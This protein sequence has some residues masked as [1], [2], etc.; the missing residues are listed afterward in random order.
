MESL[1]EDDLATDEAIDLIQQ[2]LY[3]ISMDETGKDFRDAKE[4]TTSTLDYIAAMK[5]RGNSIL[6]GMD[7]GYAELNRMTAGFGH[8]DLVIIA[9]RPSMG[10]TAFVLNIASKILDHGQGV[11]VFSLEMPAEQLMLRMMSAKASIALQDLRV[12]NLSDE[13]WRV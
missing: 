12:G 8:G 5:E 1:I 2:K 7:T 11:A 3:K 10:K 6:V 13:Q 4:V 9:A